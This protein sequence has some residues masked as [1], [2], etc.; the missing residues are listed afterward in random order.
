M[1]KVFAFL[2]VLA[3]TIAVVGFTANHS[4]DAA[5]KFTKDPTLSEN[6]IPMYVMNSI[7]TT[8]P[9]FYD[10]QALADDQWGGASRM[11]PWNE[12]K[13]QIKQVDADGVYTGKE[14]A[15]YLPGGTNA[16]SQAAA[17]EI[18]YF[19]VEEGQVVFYRQEG[20][21]ITK[22]AIT[23]NE[24]SSSSLSH[25]A[26]N[27]A[28]EEVTFIPEEVIKN[29]VIWYRSA[30]VMDA[31][32]RI[33]RGIANDKHYVS[34]VD[35]TFIDAN[36]QPHY[37]PAEYCYVDGKVTEMGDGIVCDKVMEPKVDPDGQ[38]V[39]D[40]FG[41]QV[42]VETE[43][44]AIYNT[45][46]VFDW[47]PADKHDPATVNTV[48]YLAEGW[49]A[50]LWDKAI[51]EE[52]GVLRIAFVSSSAKTF[53]LT[54][55]QLEV[56]TQ[57]IAERNANKV[58]GDPIIEEP[59]AT[60]DRGTM[61]KSIT[62][63]NNGYVYDY[64]YLDNMNVLESCHFIDIFNQ[65]YKYGRKLDEAGKGMSYVATFNFSA[66]PLLFK[67]VIDNEKGY[68][69]LGTTN[70]VEVMKG[71][72]FI[73]SKNIDI[74]GM[75][76]YWK[77]PGDVRSF[78]SDVTALDLFIDTSV[79][80]AGF[81]NQ[82]SPAPKYANM[83]ELLDDLAADVAEY[84]AKDGVDKAV[85]LEWLNKGS[86]MASNSNP[87]YDTAKGLFPAA[88]YGKNDGFFTKNWA[89]WGFF[90]KAY[91][92]ATAIYKSTRGSNIDE[93]LE[94]GT[95]TSTWGTYY[96]FGQYVAGAGVYA[97]E[98]ANELWAH[99]LTWDEYEIDTTDNKVNDSY[100]V[101]FKATNVNTSNSSSVTIKYVVVDSYTPILEV[102]KNNLFGEVYIEGGK[103]V[104]K[105]IDPMKLCTGY[106]A[107]YNGNDIKGNDISHQIVYESE[108]LDFAKP[109]EGNH[110]VTA[111]L[112]NGT[113]TVKTQ[114]VV[115]VEDMT[116][117]RVYTR[118]LVI[119]YGSDFQAKDGVVYAWDNVDGNLL[120]DQNDYRN[121]CNDISE[122][123]VDIK[124]PGTYTVMLE[125]SDKSGNTVE[126]SYEVEVLG[127]VT[128]NSDIIKLTEELAGKINTIE[129]KYN[130]L[131]EKVADINMGTTAPAV[132]C[133]NTAAVVLQ[134]LAA[135][136][137]VV[138]FLKK[139]H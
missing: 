49:D 59:T 31:E 63:P 16:S 79:N 114:F 118:D 30:L 44:D 67:D 15:I 105:A 32:G 52:G 99:P 50:T 42:M 88:A 119:Q 69:K 68:R 103:A 22:M 41:Q 39:L 116:A 86:G 90:V 8:F 122:E 64:G 75:A 25:L 14:Y 137:L 6:D 102:N 73:P 111:T 29:K 35:S 120:G 126:V 9:Q 133:G 71:E 83:A 84:L 19:M 17:N 38:P 96:D 135:A 34:E 45:R 27:I 106:D 80:N 136:S 113:K 23:D 57:T 11:Y 132:K 37:V 48:P 24:Y 21:K 66:K 98:G 101:T 70:V 65:A 47:V 51:E 85:V 100:T 110:N 139:K 40:E 121:W 18:G 94:K 125:V 82:V 130:E 74:N 2:S 123:V 60:T 107:Q 12:V 3:L 89:K 95:V 92:S 7:Y 112:T 26:K 91:D 81:V 138:V 128:D 134:L 77:T 72:K 56:Y 53:T 129:D 115:K 131:A 58:D 55:E 20:S 5:E 104:C 93:F 10:N 62:V 97:E 109:V 4:V 76:I 36:G 54:P 117:P 124:T 78:T 33:I 13:L 1:K 43:K 87:F 46:F 127:L 108:T 28:G 61:I